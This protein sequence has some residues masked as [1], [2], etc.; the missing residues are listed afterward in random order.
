MENPFADKDS[1]MATPGSFPSL[2]SAYK[3]S[4]DHDSPTGK[5][6]ASQGLVNTG[7]D[8]HDQPPSYA[9]VAAIQ[10]DSDS[11]Y[12]PHHTKPKYAVGSYGTDKPQIPPLSQLTASHAVPPLPPRTDTAQHRQSK[13]ARVDYD[14]TATWH[15]PH[16]RY[17]SQEPQ[18]TIDR[19]MSPDDYRAMNESIERKQSIWRRYPAPM[20]T[21]LFGFLFPPIWLVGSVWILSKHATLKRWGIVNAIGAIAALIVLLIIR[22]W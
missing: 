5:E 21:F 18:H 9:Q 14:K 6:D 22:P 20:F 8:K 15:S 12:Q 16:Y 17:D 1:H 19:P 10:A 2:Q 3:D 4:Y 13:D 7:Q 11:E